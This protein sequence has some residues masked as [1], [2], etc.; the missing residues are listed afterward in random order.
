MLC[1]VGAK[2]RGGEWRPYQGRRVLSRRRVYGGTIDDKIGLELLDSL[3]GGSNSRRAV[4]PVTRALTLWLRGVYFAV[5]TFAI[6]GVLYVRET[7]VS[8]LER[9]TGNTVFLHRLSSDMNL[10]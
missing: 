2:H 1:M 6:A 4:G 9:R 3:G 8:P 10:L 5:A 7:S